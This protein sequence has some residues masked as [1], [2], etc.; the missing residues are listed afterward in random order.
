MFISEGDEHYFGKKVGL[1][2]LL[3]ATGWEGENWLDIMAQ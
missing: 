3:N 2:M 1:L